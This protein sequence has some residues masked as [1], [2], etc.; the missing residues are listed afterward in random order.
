[1]EKNRER[2]LRTSAVAIAVVDARNYPKWKR[3]W[4]AEASALPMTD[5]RECEVC[6]SVWSNRSERK[7]IYT[8]LGG[9]NGEN[10]NANCSQ[11]KNESR[12]C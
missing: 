4:L 7:A 2:E 3:E 5:Q 9:Q 10:T 12:N 11:K 1:M 6:V 8:G